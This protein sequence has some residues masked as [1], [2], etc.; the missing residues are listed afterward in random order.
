MHDNDSETSFDAILEAEFGDLK[1]DIPQKHQRTSATSETISGRNISECDVRKKNLIV[2]AEVANEN[3]A[4]VIEFLNEKDVVGNDIEDV[5][6]EE[7]EWDIDVEIDGSDPCFK[8]PSFMEILFGCQTDF[9]NDKYQEL[10]ERYR[11][12]QEKNSELM[13]EIDMLNRDIASSG[14]DEE[15]MRDEHMR[16]QEQF[17]CLKKD[18]LMKSDEMIKLKEDYF[19]MKHDLEVMTLK[20]EDATGKSKS[21]LKLR[22]AEDRRRKQLI[23]ENRALRNQRMKL[24]EDFSF[25]EKLTSENKNARK[26]QEIR[27]LTSFMKMIRGMFKNHGG[28]E[29]ICEQMKQKKLQDLRKKYVIHESDFDN[30]F[31]DEIVHVSTEE[32]H[33][34]S[35][36]ASDVWSFEDA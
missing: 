33:V 8:V 25:L 23:E 4:S 27:D 7:F 2:K 26:N 17:A 32:D 35:K 24:K 1:V 9:V 21:F 13:N 18:H 20:Y 3:E 16:L 14:F 11:A 22:E 6:S 12:L 19:K 31:D 29:D 34:Q 28:F 36:E 15:K 30:L 10:Y 5:A